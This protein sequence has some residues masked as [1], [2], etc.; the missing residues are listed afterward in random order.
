MADVPTTLIPIPF[1][2]CELRK[3]AALRFCG[4]IAG[5]VRPGVGLRGDLFF[6]ELHRQN[7][8]EPI[9][10]GQLFECVRLEIVVELAGITP[11]RHVSRSEAIATVEGA[12]NRL[13]AVV[14]V[15]TVTSQTVRNAVRPTTGGD[16]AKSANPR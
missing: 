2:C 4:E 15:G 3:G 6:C 10:A 11:G 5:F 1:R 7:G 16:I 8:D 13:G 9:P 12:L 14:D